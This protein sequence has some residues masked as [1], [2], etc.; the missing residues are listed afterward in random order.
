MAERE[1]IP[2]IV[3]ERRGS[4][5]G[6]FIWGALLGAGIALL[7]APRSGKET[8]RQLGN[9][10]RRVRDAAEDA[11]RNVQQSVSGTLDEL[12]EQVSDRVDAARRAMDAGREAA[13][14]SRSELERRVQEARAATEQPPHVHGEPA[15]AGEFMGEIDVVEGDEFHS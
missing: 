12:R 13:L 5:V 9:G 1:D 15:G 10:V 7:L 6:S 4:G 8:R 3:V 14:R 11:V 2:Y